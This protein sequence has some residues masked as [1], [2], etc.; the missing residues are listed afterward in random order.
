[1]IGDPKVGKTTYL[2]ALA[3][4]VASGTDFLGEPTIQMPVVYLSEQTQTVFW[5]QLTPGLRQNPDFHY[6]TYFDNAWASWPDFIAFGVEKCIAVGSQLLVIDTVGKFARLEG[7]DENSAGA[8]G[9]ALGVLDQAKSH[10]ISPILAKHSKKSANGIIGA[11]SGSYRWDAEADILLYLTKERDMPKH[12]R[13]LENAGRI[14]HAQ[15]EWV[16]EYDML[17]GSINLLGAYEE[18][19]HESVITKIDDT[20]AV[21]ETVELKDIYE[22]C[23]DVNEDSIRNALHRSDRY[24]RVSR[25]KYRRG[26]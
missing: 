12:R 25:G 16:A 5:Q 15:S 6:A 22:Q 11:S 3:D 24:E 19:A 26:R 20:V 18:V 7:D 13:K 4:A 9:Q 10:G 1:V 8:V 14:Q 23:P 21:D 17:T 2:L